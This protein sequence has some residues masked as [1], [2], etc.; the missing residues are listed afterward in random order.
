MASGQK[1]DEEHGFPVLMNSIHFCR[2]LII[3]SHLASF[4]NLHQQRCRRENAANDVRLSRLLPNRHDADFKLGASCDF[5]NENKF[6][7]SLVGTAR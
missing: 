3:G 2:A 5:E 6:H 1:D 4:S 7:A